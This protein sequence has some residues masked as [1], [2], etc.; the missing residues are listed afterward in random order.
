MIERSCLEYSDRTAFIQ[1]GRK[2]DYAQLDRLSGQFAAWLQVRAGL[3]KGDRIAIMLP[4]LLQYPVVIFTKLAAD[5]LKG[6]L[7]DRTGRAA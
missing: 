6:R 7:E 2:L 1:M 3:R 5:A 4:N